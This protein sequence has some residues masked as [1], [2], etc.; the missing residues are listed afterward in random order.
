MPTKLNAIEAILPQVQVPQD[1]WEHSFGWRCVALE[2]APGLGYRQYVLCHLLVVI[3]H[4]CV[5]QLID[6][7]S[8][9]PVN[10]LPPPS[11]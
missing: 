10:L 3:Y 1:L 4:S 11:S 2:Y 9:Y 8:R 5:G 6:S 7:A